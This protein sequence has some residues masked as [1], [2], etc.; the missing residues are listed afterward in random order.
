MKR[1]LALT[2][3]VAL[4]GIGIPVTAGAAARQGTASLAGIAKNAGGQALPNYTVRLRNVAN[5]QLAG[6]TTSNVEGAFSFTGLAQGN[7]VI[8]VVDAAGRIIA[9]STSISVAAGAAVTGV[10]VTIS[11]AGAAAAAAAAGGGIGAFFT[12]TSGILLLA[13]AGAG[14]AAGIVKATASPSR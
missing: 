5:G 6:T 9:T 1:L 14:V 7:Y 2:L 12:S 11:A 3:A 13:A 8:E 10:A 4:V